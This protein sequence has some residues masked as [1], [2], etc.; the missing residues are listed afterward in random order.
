MWRTDTPAFVI[1]MQAS[2]KWLLKAKAAS[3]QLL[4]CTFALYLI[5]HR[6]D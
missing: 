1:P 4:G 5:S 6:V 2:S 3:M